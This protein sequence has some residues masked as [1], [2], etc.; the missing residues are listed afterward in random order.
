[1][2]RKILHLL[3]Q[4]EI[5]GLERAALRL[6]RRGRERGGDHSILLFNKPFRSAR[7]DYVPG[8]VPTYFIP[9]ESVGGLPR[10]WRD[11]Y[12]TT[13]SKSFMRTTPRRFSTVLP[14]RRS[15]EPQHP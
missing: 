7:L 9:R 8:D 2:P 12:Q 5:G 10:D 13:A 11:F 15:P 3:G 4:L 1:M 6:A 14:R